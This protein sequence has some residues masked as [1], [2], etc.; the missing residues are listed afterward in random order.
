MIAF[1]EKLEKE[2]KK[3]GFDNGKAISA[4]AE[5]LGAFTYMSAEIPVQNTFAFGYDRIH[6]WFVLREPTP[7]W[8]DYI[9]LIRAS[10]GRKTDFMDNESQIVIHSSYLNPPMSTKEKMI[11]KVYSAAKDERKYHAK[12]I[13]QLLQDRKDRQEDRKHLGNRR[14][15]AF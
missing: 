12:I 6:F 3:L 13:C 8:P 11:S 5:H 14:N 2:F 7:E 4:T 10:S 1:D 15:A 9:Q